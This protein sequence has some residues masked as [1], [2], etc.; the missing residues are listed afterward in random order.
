MTITAQPPPAAPAGPGACRYP[1]CPSPAR[2]AAAPG[3][4]PGYCGREVPEDRDGTVALVRHTALTAFRRRRQL[5]GQAD[6]GRPVTAAIGRA[7]AVRDDAV[8]TVS[9]LGAQLAAAIDQLA[10]IGEQLAAA[11]DPEAAEA[12][13]ETV[14]AEAAAHLAAR[15]AAEL[16]A[17]E[18]RQAAAEAIAA[19]E[20]AEQSRGEAEEAARAAVRELHGERA[21]HQAGLD[22]ARAAAEQAA[23]DRDADR[24]QHQASLA[25]LDGTAAA[26]RDQLARAEAALDRERERQ[27]ETTALLHQMLTAAD[28]SQPKAAARRRQ[29][30]PE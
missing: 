4:P 10:L 13:A 20:A 7:A 6:D 21:A 29:P 1:G 9:R 5:A 22:A 17:A 15:H 23:R 12:Q 8:A 30:A 16:D 26:L 11:G 14:R 2:D 18:A 3:R 19:M 27:H 24:R 28:G 25:A